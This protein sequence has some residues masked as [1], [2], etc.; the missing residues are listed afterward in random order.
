MR[1]L[2]GLLAAQPFR[3]TLIGDASLMRRPMQR[4]ATPLRDMGAIV[5]TA[6]AGRP[7]LRV[8]CPAGAWLRGMT[9]RLAVDSAQV[10][11]AILLAGLYAHGPTRIVPA[12]AGRDH[13]QRMLGA[14]HIPI[15]QTVDATSLQPTTGVHGPA[16][17][18]FTVPGDASA[19]AFAL[20]LACAVPGSQLQVVDCGVNPTRIGYLDVLRQAG[21]HIA[22]TLHR[23]ELGEPVGQIRVQGRAL[24]PIEIRGATLVACLDEVPALAAAGAIAGCAVTVRDAVELR[25][26]E[27][28]RIAGIVEL[29]ACFGARVRERR[30]GFTLASR[31]TL[32]A[33]PV[34]SHGDHRLAMAAAMLASRCVGESIIDDVACVATS[35]PDF[36]ADFT[37]LCQPSVS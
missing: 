24:R 30:D 16:T 3:S 13:T 15:L 36:A 25:H 28:D 6:E 19:A 20:A 14:L 1:L 8:G 34:S 12:S 22:T 35:Y 11:S 18:Q 33:A 10:R 9:H 2:A 17:F 4:L 23:T 5:E 21:A 32:R 27:S 31:A 37:R 7:P 26:K 29:L